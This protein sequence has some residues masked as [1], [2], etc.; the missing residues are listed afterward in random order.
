MERIRVIFSVS[1]PSPANAIQNFL[2]SKAS[3][4]FNITIIASPTVS[5]FIGRTNELNNLIEYSESESINAAGHLE[6]LIRK[7]HPDIIIATVGGP[8]L[9]VNEIV[10][11]IG[12]KL[13]VPVALLQ[14]YPGDFNPSM[15]QLPDHIF[16]ATDFG[17][18]ITS[19]KLGP[20][21]AQTPAMHVIGNLLY[22]H[23]NQINFDGIRKKERSDRGI[24]PTDNVILLALQPSEIYEDYRTSINLFTSAITKMPELS[25]LK[26]IISPHPN[27][28]DDSFYLEIKKTLGKFLVEVDF[29]LVNRLHLIA[30]ADVVVSAFSTCCLDAIEINKRL[31][32]DVIRHGFVMSPKLLSE[33]DEYAGFSHLEFFGGD[34]IFQELSSVKQLLRRKYNPCFRLEIPEIT[35]PSYKLSNRI[36]DI[37]QGLC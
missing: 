10:M 33:V 15:N 37:V 28:I 34:N 31:S 30:M 21:R 23:F 2:K 3:T 4:L 36:V 25:G 1:D 32:D 18:K 9:T 8:N 13:A 11:H 24:L 26:L 20:S 16:C 35:K 7:N 6:K 14:I 27:A 12:H 5:N 19:I 17:K 29:S 22:E